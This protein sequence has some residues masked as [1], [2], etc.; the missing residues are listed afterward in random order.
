MRTSLKLLTV[1]LVLVT[2]AVAGCSSTTAL[3]AGAI[4]D[5]VASPA[6]S[7]D[8]PTSSP[9]PV[10]SPT[11]TPTE[12]PASPVASPTDPPVDPAVMVGNKQGNNDVCEPDLAYTCGDTGA[13]GVGTVFYASKASFKCGDGMASSCNYLEVAPNG[14]NGTLVDCINVCGGS[15]DSTSDEG[16]AYLGYLYCTGSGDTKI[17][18]NA[19]GNVIGS[20]FTNTSAMLTMCNSGDA[21]EQVRGYTGGGQMD[22]SLPSSDE[23]NALYFYTG[24][25]AIGGFDSGRGY[26]SSSQ[27]D[28]DNAWKQYFGNGSQRQTEKTVGLNVRAVRAF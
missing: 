22:W 27:I 14:W 16:S 17:I 23:L 3:P 6:S 19:S 2:A 13:S 9:D 5:D 11:A 1:G 10:V 21:A 20:G 26:W 25:D 7:S 12:A 24:R 28:K 18:P 15:P 8:G 4:Q